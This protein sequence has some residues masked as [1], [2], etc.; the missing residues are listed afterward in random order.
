S[1]L[2]SPRILLLPCSGNILYFRCTAKARYGGTP[3]TPRR[4]GGYLRIPGVWVCAAKLPFLDVTPRSWSPAF[5]SQR[6]L[7]QN[8][9]NSLDAES[10]LGLVLREANSQTFGMS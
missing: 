10:C 8:T 9:I 3:R 7:T 1:G 4:R 5:L 6:H 2:A